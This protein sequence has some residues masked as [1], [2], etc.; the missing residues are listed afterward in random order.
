MILAQEN[1]LDCKNYI[2][3]IKELYAWHFPE[4]GILVKDELTFV[5]VVKLMGKYFLHTIFTP[6]TVD[7]C[8][9]VF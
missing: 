1:H 4:L 3:K 9:L 7:S 6:S 5:R 8:Y 2:T